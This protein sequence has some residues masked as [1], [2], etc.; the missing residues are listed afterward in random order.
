MRG[1]AGL[2]VSPEPEEMEV[3]SQ[4]PLLIYQAGQRGVIGKGLK[5]L[6]AEFGYV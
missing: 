1:K 4:R 5:K 2:F 3:A 6:C